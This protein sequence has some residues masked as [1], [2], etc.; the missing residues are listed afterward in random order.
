MIH[1]V[2]QPCGDLACIPRRPGLRAV[3]ARFVG[4]RPPERAR[5]EPRLHDLG[6]LLGVDLCVRVQRGQPFVAPLDEEL[7]RLAL[8]RRLFRALQL[9]VEWRRAGETKRVRERGDRAHEKPAALGERHFRRQ[10]DLLGAAVAD[11]FDALNRITRIELSVDRQFE[12]TGLRLEDVA[13]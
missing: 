7:R 4:F 1:H 11:K 6:A 3:C 2:V 10:F 9:N 13:G 12:R 5:F 8:F